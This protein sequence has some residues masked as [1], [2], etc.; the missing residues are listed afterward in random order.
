VRARWPTIGLSYNEA[1]YQI[2]FWDGRRFDNE[3]LTD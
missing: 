1:S 3:Y 2:F